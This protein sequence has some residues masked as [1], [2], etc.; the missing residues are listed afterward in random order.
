MARYLI[1]VGWLA[2]LMGAAL[3]PPVLLASAAGTAESSLGVAIVSV[4]GML[5]LG[6]IATVVWGGRHRSGSGLPSGVRMAI[7]ANVLF[8]AF[9]ALELSDR[10]IERNGKLFY[11]STFLLP[12]ALALFYGLLTARPWAWRTSR[13]AAALGVV[14]FLGFLVLIPFAHLETEG[15]PVPWQGRLYMSAVTLTFAAVLAAAYRA[16]GRPETRSYFGEMHRQ[17]AVD[18]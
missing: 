12:P 1:A 11:W 14:W 2:I 15:V 13:G 4:G 10:L 5:I 9:F 8:L 16:L 3:I 18:R 17:V 7:A 6:G